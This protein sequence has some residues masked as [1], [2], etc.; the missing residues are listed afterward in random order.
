MKYFVVPLSVSFFLLFVPVVI[1]AKPTRGEI[2]RIEAATRV[3][4]E[5]PGKIPARILENA[6]GIAVIPDVFKAGF[7]YGAEMG[8]GV[9]VS[10][11]PDGNWSPPAFITFAG[12]S[13]GLQIG[14]ETKDIVLVFNTSRSMDSIENGW[15]KLGVGASVAAGPV[16]ATVSATTDLPEVYSYTTSMGVFIGAMVGGALLSFDFDSNRDFYGISDPLKMKATEIPKPASE[17]SC[18]VTK[19]TGA[20]ADVCG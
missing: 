11:L 13:F 2:D 4:N 9:F 6:K 16:G 10:R 12:A 19:V 15:M 7:I 14:G 5:V 17:F 8:G 1:V 3:F 18:E 20:P